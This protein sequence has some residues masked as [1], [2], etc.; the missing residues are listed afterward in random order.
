MTEKTCHAFACTTQVGLTQ[1]LGF[2]MGDRANY[3]IIESGKYDIYFANCGA[4]SIAQDV[5]GGVEK[6]SSYIRSCTITNELLS[7]LFCE[8]GILLDLDKK[9]YPP[10]YPLPFNQHIQE[11]PQ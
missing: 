4:L 8:G 2:I 10:L 3:V 5:F 9:P 1:A 7:E 6:T 11:R